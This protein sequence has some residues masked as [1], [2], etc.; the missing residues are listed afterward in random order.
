MS[1]VTFG[2]INQST[3][4]ASLGNKICRIGSNRIIHSY[5]RESDGYGLA[6]VY[7]FTD[8]V[9]NKISTKIIASESVNDVLAYNCPTLIQLEKDKF[10]Y[11]YIG[12]GSNPNLRIYTVDSSGNFTNQATI[13]IETSGTWY[14]RHPVI[15]QT[16]PN[17]IIYA[18][19]WDNGSTFEIHIICVTI[20]GYTMT[21]GSIVTVSN[22]TF[23]RLAGCFTANNK[24]TFI[25]PDPTDSYKLYGIACTTPSGLDAAGRV[26]T[27]GSV[28]KLVDSEIRH[29]NV[30]YIDDNKIAIAYCLYNGNGGAVKP[31]TLSGTTFILGTQ[32]KHQLSNNSWNNNIERVNHKEF[33]IAYCDGSDSTKGKIKYGKID[34]DTLTIDSFE[35]EQ[36]YET[37]STG[38]LNDF[39]NSIFISGNIILLGYQDDDD[40]DYP[41]LIAGSFTPTVTPLSPDS[42]LAFDG[43]EKNTLTWEYLP[44]EPFNNFDDWTDNYKKIGTEISSIVSG[45]LRLILPNTG[46]SQITVR[47]TINVISN[48]VDLQIDI[49]NYTPY[50]ATDAFN[51]FFRLVDSSGNNKFTVY[52][53]KYDNYRCFSVSQINGGSLVYGTYL[54]SSA[55]PTKLRIVIEGENISGWVYD[56][57]WIFLGTVDFLGYIS[58]LTIF[59]ISAT[60]RNNYGGYVDFDNLINN[61]EYTSYWDTSPGVTKATGT[62]IND[63]NSPHEHTGLT[64]AQPYYYIIT[65]KTDF[66]ESI[67][68][69]EVN[70][71]PYAVLIPTIT[72]ENGDSENIINISEIAGATS[73]N[74]Y[75]SLTEGVTKENGIKIENTGRNYNHKNLTIQNYYYIA[76]AVGPGGESNISNEICLKPYQQDK[77]F[78]HT[79]QMLDSLLYQYRKD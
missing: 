15:V 10:A 66:E 43:P 14:C 6:N 37:G 71:T 32:S 30:C 56:S 21:K 65:G 28:T 11:A 19:H 47:R 38:G 22:K 54:H 57:K 31:I 72:G 78:N 79:E 34:W 58:Q 76:T 25:W 42:L 40:S 24:A 60:D 17:K 27:K 48:N 73:Y 49:S 67:D 63:I 4:V 1:I 5:V 16:E 3:N 39:G 36:T 64:P 75:Y 50:D 62:P 45:K 8:N 55:I 59:E 12:P 69:S 23:Y 9:L 70:A 2:S 33:I 46:D 18:Y 52:C 13:V 61:I 77:I 20:S 74:I 7:D 68:S 53:T 41:K 44:D 35:S 26:I 51:L 29:P